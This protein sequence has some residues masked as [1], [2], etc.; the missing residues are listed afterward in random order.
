MNWKCLNFQMNLI[1]LKSPIDLVYFRARNKFKNEVS[2]DWATSQEI[3]NDFF[4]IE[5]SKNLKSW[6]IICEIDASFNPSQNN[7]YSYIHNQE[8]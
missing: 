8:E 2:L 3:N 4:I 1:I 5:K 6:D 7:A